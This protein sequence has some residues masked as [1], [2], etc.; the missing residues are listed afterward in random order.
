MLAKPITGN[1]VGLTYF[2]ITPFQFHAAYPVSKT[3][4][5]EQTYEGTIEY[6][7]RKE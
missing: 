7:V 6:L 4:P 5:S 2:F 1:R 3:R